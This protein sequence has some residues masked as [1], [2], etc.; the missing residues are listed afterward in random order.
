M[1][2]KKEIPVI[3]I[4]GGIGSGKSTLV[5]E[6]HIYCTNN[7]LKI[8]T[9]QEPVDSWVNIK[10]SDGINIIQA[11]YA[12][13]HKHSFSFQMLAY[14]SRLQ[15]LQESYFKALNEGYDF[16]VCERSLY[17]DKNVFCKM[18]YNEGKIDEYGYQIYNK[19]FE[20]FQSF[21]T[22]F[23]FVYL[24][25]DYNICFQRINKRNRNGEE[26]IPLEYL[27]I[28]NTY[29]DNWL[30]NGDNILFLDGNEDLK[31]NPEILRIH[32]MKIIHYLNEISL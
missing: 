1:S 20:Y 26:N 2:N 16:I 30:D 23:H 21:L 29:H 15:K 12:D 6:L 11:F 31:T 14:I 19:W 7:N 13:Q 32:I 24:K 5:K 27:K 3:F 28:N 25:T 8:L 22:N 18:L 10:N 9:V 17:T 4:E